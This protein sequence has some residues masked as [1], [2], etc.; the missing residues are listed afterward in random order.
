MS[1]KS[2]ILE[3][4]KTAMK[5]KETARLSTLRMLTAAMKQK[6]VDERIELD[7]AAVL[8]IVEKLIKQRK[9]SI[10]QFGKAGR[11]DLVDAETAELAVLSAYLPAQLSEPEVLATIDAAIASTGAAGPKDMGKL[12]GVLKPQL[13]GKADMSKVS[14]LVKQRLGS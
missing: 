4:V 8:A 13:A 10:E 11:Q 1:L 5:A 14:G 9:D 2:Q 6:E 3:D 12:M 7:D